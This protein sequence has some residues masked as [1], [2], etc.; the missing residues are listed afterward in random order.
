MKLTEKEIIS[1]RPVTY[2]GRG[3]SIAIYV[4]TDDSNDVVEFRMLLSQIAPLIAGKE[5]EAVTARKY[6]YLTATK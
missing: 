4:S 6:K 5:W 1:M 3:D 2:Y